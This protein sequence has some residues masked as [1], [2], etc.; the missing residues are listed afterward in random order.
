MHREIS[1]IAGERGLGK[2]Q[3]KLAN[4][5]GRSSSRLNKP[6]TTGIFR[7]WRRESKSR[8]MEG[9][10]PWRLNDPRKEQAP[11]SSHAIPRAARGSCRT[12]TRGFHTRGGWKT[13]VQF[14][15]TRKRARSGATEASSA[16]P[17]GSFPLS[18]AH[19][20][21]RRAPVLSL[22]LFHSGTGRARCRPLSDP[23]SKPPRRSPRGCAAPMR[24]LVELI[25]AWPGLARGWLQ[26]LSPRGQGSRRRGSR[27]R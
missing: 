26:P 2:G 21:P 13:V 20:A 8:S 16:L 25:T 1:L 18:A 11:P 19:A 5:R 10:K 17:P 4:H 6:G 23:A 7:S 24:E 12:Q 15:R 22:A 14:A 3:I 27:A 9:R